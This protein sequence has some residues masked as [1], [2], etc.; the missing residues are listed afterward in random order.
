MIIQI[1]LFEAAVSDFQLTRTPHP[2]LIGRGRGV[3]NGAFSS[4]ASGRPRLRISIFRHQPGNAIAAAL[5]SKM[6]ATPEIH[7]GYARS[8]APCAPAM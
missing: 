2:S 7:H 1:G 8:H 6:I 5:A 3:L 4:V